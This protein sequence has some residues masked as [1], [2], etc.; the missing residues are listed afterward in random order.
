MPFW[1]SLHFLLKHDFSCRIVPN[2]F[3]WKEIV[4][5]VVWLEVKLFEHFRSLH[6]MEPILLM[7]KTSQ[8]PLHLCGCH[9]ELS[10]TLQPLH[11]L[12]TVGDPSAHYHIHLTVLY[13][14]YCGDETHKV[15][16]YTR[17]L[18]M[19]SPPFNLAS[20]C[21]Y[22]WWIAGLTYSSS[23]LI[24]IVACS[25]RAWHHHTAARAWI[26]HIHAQTS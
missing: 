20:Q 5:A 25:Q 12:S 13:V 18:K 21:C 19:L 7:L 16:S 1:P 11:Q 9:F 4:F 24:W 3:N 14:I 15:A 8:Y 2:E 26:A 10:I 17:W 22:V 6:Y 23:D